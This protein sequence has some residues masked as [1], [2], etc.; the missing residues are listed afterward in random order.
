MGEGPSC[1]SAQARGRGARRCLSAWTLSIIA[2]R[3]K[4]R[5]ARMVLRAGRGLGACG[6][7]AVFEGAT[8]HGAPS[9]GASMIVLASSPGEPWARDPLLA[10]AQGVQLP[11]RRMARPGGEDDP[12]EAPAPTAGEPDGLVPLAAVAEA[13][14]FST[15]R[16][17]TFLEG[18]G[19]LVRQGNRLF[20][21]RAK[22]GERF[23]EIADELERL[24]A[25]PPGA[26]RPL[27]HD[28]LSA[29]LRGLPLPKRRR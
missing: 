29:Q 21:D 5:G 3:P 17:R 8:K 28:E 12:N 1:L 14:G 25:L 26:P 20:A 2:P 22:L 10:H 13:T 4:R 6:I 9:W 23:P 11:S 24:A 15:Y 18:E 16:A 19:L 27:S 7:P